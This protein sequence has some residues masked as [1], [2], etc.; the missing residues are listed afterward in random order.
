MKP[1]VTMWEP[2]FYTAFVN[3]NSEASMVVE[4]V[5]DKGAVLDEIVLSTQV[6]A[7]IYNPSTG[8]RMH[9]AGKQLG[10]LVARYLSSRLECQK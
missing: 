3:Q 9:T 4:I 8:G 5:D 1:K 7:S 6:G 2:G 10:K